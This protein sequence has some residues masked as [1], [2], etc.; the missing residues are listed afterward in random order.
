MTAEPK[1]IA[2]NFSGGYVPG[3][4]AVITGVVLAANA[5]G[6]EVVGIRDGFEGLLFPERYPDG[7]LVNLIPAIVKNLAGAGGCILGTA[8]RNDPFH[9]RTIN[10]ENQVEEVDR[11]DELLEKIERE[12]IDAVISVVGPRALSILWKLSRK[13]LGRSAC[14]SRLKTI[15]QPRCC[16]LGSTAP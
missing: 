15:W 8:A 10:A 3:L 14:R 5:Q 9:V 4:N 13:G 7:G 11:S 2:I 12:K 16:P 1:R 6:W